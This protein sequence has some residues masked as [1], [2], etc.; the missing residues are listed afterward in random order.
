VKVKISAI[1]LN[2]WA[3][4]CETFTNTTGGKGWFL[5]FHHCTPS[6]TLTEVDMIR[7]RTRETKVE[8]CYWRFGL[9][10]YLSTAGMLQ[11]K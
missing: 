8:K 9:G 11:R 1:F 6:A 3:N 4:L 10:E 7:A 5:D 2:R